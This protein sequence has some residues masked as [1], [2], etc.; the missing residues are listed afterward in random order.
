M[1]G[2]CKTCGHEAASHGP[3]GCTT[4]VPYGTSTMCACRRR[5]LA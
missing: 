4:F 3:Y 5:N 2:A 1:K